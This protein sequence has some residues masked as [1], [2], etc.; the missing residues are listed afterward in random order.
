MI[1][2]FPTRS[3]AHVKQDANIRIEKRGESVEE[4]SMAVEL[5]G[6]LLLEAEQNLN[7]HHSLLSTLKAK[8]WI[9]RDL[10]RVLRLAWER[11]DVLTS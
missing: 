2:G 6:I 5:F 10:C 7:R 3:R 8:V 4:P 11:C 1:Y 9:D